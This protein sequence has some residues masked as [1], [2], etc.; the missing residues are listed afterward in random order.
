MLEEIIIILGILWLLG[1]IAV[2]MGGGII[3]ILVVLV[4]IVIL[5]RLARGERL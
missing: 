2:P 1:V 4:I 5:I 3:N